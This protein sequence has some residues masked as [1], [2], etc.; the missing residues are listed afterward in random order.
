MRPQTAVLLSILV[1]VS[2]GSI[3][4]GASGSATGTDAPTIGGLDGRRIPD[5]S[6]DGIVS[7]PR[8]APYRPWAGPLV[9]LVASALG[10]V[11]IVGFCPRESRGA[12]LGLLATSALLRVIT[13]VA[14]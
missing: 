8:S 2:C 3:G 9:V 11:L 12:A 10:V 5:A 7:L 13:P 1:V 14:F 4:A 6:Q